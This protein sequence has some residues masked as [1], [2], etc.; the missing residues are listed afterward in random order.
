MREGRRKAKLTLQEQSR[1]KTVHWIS[2]EFKNE[3]N[4]DYA[5]KC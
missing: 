2:S 4:C 1:L 3:V 5:G